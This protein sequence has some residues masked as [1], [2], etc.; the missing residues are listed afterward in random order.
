MP[1]Y[2]YTEAPPV[3]TTEW[4]NALRLTIDLNGEHSP[5][6]SKSVYHSVYQS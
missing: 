5:K 2:N 4:S 3:I 6:N 1:N